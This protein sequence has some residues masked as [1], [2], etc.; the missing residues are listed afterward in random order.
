MVSY[1]IL[2]LVLIIKSCTKLMEIPDSSTQNLSVLPFEDDS[3]TIDNFCYGSSNNAVITG[4]PLGQ[5]SL[6]N[7]PNG[8]FINSFNGELSNTTSSGIYTVEYTTPGSLTSCSSSS[9]QNV[10]GY[11]IPSNPNTTNSYEDCADEI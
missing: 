6:T 4:V 7:N 3:F 1:Q 8:A 2:L 9:Q 5:F 11:P 10:E